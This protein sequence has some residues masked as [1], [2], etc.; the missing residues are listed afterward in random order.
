MNWYKSTLNT[1]VLVEDTV[2]FSPKAKPM[3]KLAYSSRSHELDIAKQTNGDGSK[4]KIQFTESKN[5]IC[6]VA[7]FLTELYSF[8]LFEETWIYDKKEMKRAVKTYNR[9]INV[10]EDLKADT[11]DDDLPT[12][13]LQGAAREELRFIDIERKKPLNNRSLEAARHE[14]G[15]VDWRNSLYGNR[16]PATTVNINNNGTINLSTAPSTGLDLTKKE[17]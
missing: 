9:I 1:N 5:Q 2:A 7:R 11:E 6:I 8:P 13:S 10:L 12:P 14:P 16:Y 17:G 3:V 15:V 4:I